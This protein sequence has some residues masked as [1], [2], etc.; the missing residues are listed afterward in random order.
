MSSNLLRSA[1]YFSH[2]M[3]SNSGKR[4]PLLSSLLKSVVTSNTSSAGGSQITWGH[5][6]CAKYFHRENSLFVTN[7]VGLRGFSVPETCETRQALYPNNLT[8]R[9]LRAAR[10]A[11]RASNWSSP[12]G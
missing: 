2:K 4:D 11:I 9:R 1:G 5:V 8:F 6:T 7:G 10:P 3:I 12:A